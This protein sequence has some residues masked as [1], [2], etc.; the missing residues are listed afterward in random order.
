MKTFEQLKREVSEGRIR[1]REFI[2]RATAG[3]HQAWLM[4]STPKAMP[5]GVATATDSVALTSP[6]SPTN[7]TVGV[8]VRTTEPFTVALTTF[9][10]ASVEP[11]VP[12]VWPLAFVTLAGWVIASGWPNSSGRRGNT[13]RRSAS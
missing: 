5:A 11:I 4:P 2:K 10:S 3:R 1:R 7:S 12:V 8:C 9:T 6:G 13:T